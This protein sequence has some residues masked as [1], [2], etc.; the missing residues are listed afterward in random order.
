M[1]SSTFYA[2]LG[3][4]VLLDHGSLV[5]VYLGLRDKYVNTGDRVTRGT[6]LGTVGGSSIIG[7]DSMAFQLRRGQ[8][9][10]PPPF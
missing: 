8:Q 7:P 4:V 9:V 5:T 2:S 10:I 1:L 6:P 3:G